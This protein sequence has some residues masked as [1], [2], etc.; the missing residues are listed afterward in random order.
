[1]AGISG[2]LWADNRTAASN[3]LLDDADLASR[4]W[5]V[6]DRIVAAHSNRSARPESAVPA[7]TRATEAAPSEAGPTKAGRT[8]RLQAAA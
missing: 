2:E 3:A 4:L 6:S 1:V 5:D 8:E 7:E